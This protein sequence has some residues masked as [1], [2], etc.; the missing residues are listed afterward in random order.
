MIMIQVSG[1]T[2]RF[3]NGKGIFNVSF[4]VGGGEVLGFIG[5]NGAGK[6]TTIRHLMGF[7]KP[8]SG[9][10]RIAGYHCWLESEQ[11]KSKT[12]Y[13]PG[14]IVF[15]AGMSAS[16]FLNFQLGIRKI[17]DKSK[18]KNL[19]DRF[20]L[21]IEI[22]IIRMS[23]GMKQKLAIVSTFMGSSEVILLDEPSTGLD[24]LMQ[25]ELIA[26][27]RE[28]KGRGAT[29]LLS[30]HIFA[31]IENIADTVCFIKN[32]KI[33][34]YEKFSEIHKKLKPVLLVTLHDGN[35]TDKLHVPFTVLPDKKIGIKIDHNENEIIRQLSKCDVE[36]IDVKKITLDDIFE[37][38]YEEES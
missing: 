2:K 12:A 36:N 8:D 26:L 11:V 23:K 24:P 33:I 5:P 10:A 20:H 30:S 3:K 15:P 7:L 1:L 25:K 16:D 18:M 14:E 22:P 28:E 29:I 27:C 17:D 35:D 9:N 4:D 13:L 32:G 6:S 34:E 31:E 21:N 19:I 38:Y 37:K